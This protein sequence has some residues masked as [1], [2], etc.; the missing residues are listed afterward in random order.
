M[1]FANASFRAAREAYRDSRARYEFGLADYTDLSDTIRSVTT[2]MEQ[3]A[4]AITLANV[5]YAQLLRELLAVPT[6]TDQPV[7][8]PLVLPPSSR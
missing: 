8:L 6:K 5:S 3:R 7:E 1:P 2:A 4:S